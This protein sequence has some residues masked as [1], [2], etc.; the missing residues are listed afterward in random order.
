MGHTTRCM[1]LISHLLARGLNPIVAGNAAQI[2]LVKEAFNNRVATTALEG[3]NIS[4]SG[5]NRVAQAG[6]MLQMPGILSSIKREHDWLQQQATALKLDGIISDNRYGLYHPTI[7]SVIMTHQLHVLTG[8]GRMA[9]N[10]IQRLH[11]RYLNRFGETW[12]VDTK[13]APG[14][15][16]VLSHTA[17]MPDRYKYVGL[18][19]RFAETSPGLSCL[20]PP[21]LPE[22]EVR[23]NEH[24][25]IGGLL[26][27][28]SG[29]EPQRTA[30]SRILWRQVVGY[31]GQVTFAEGS[32][33]TETPAHIPTHITYHK[34]LGGEQL[35][36]A[37]QAANMVICRSGYSTI[38]DLAALNKKAILIPT[39]GQTE[40]QYLGSYLHERGA[41]YSTAQSGFDLGRAMK[42][43]GVF[44]YASVVGRSAYTVY[45]EVMDEWVV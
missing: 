1:P 22:G 18:L 32:D 15:A 25:G 44:P 23:S 16:G 24:R 42:E 28:L 20:A 17:R 7:P 2:T 3:Y 13:E 26:V 34:R 43:A 5:W 45:S 6:L 33:N 14:L 35:L 38:M 37:L 4:Y 8:M 39:P 11:Y 21:G 31:D 27:L 9:D 10:M 40:Q 36:Q 30:L 41:F 29:P 19:S 12:V